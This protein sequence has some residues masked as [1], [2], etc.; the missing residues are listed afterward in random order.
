MYSQKRAGVILTYLTQVIN[1]VSGLVYTPIMLRLLGQSEYGLYQLV[2]SVVSYLGLLS[3]GFSSSYLRFYSRFRADDDEDGVKGLN[4]LFM[5]TFLTIALVS[6]ACGTVLV[7]NIRLVFADGLTEAEYP[8]ATILMAL[9]VVNLALS[10]PNSVFTCWTSAQE[11][12]VFQR[13]L[14]FLGA[15]LSPLVTLPLLILGYGSVAMVVVSTSIT[16]ASLA[17]NA[18]FCLMKLG[19]RFRF[20]GLDWGLF[21]EIFAFTFFIFLNQIIDQVNWSV[22]RFLLGRMR[23]TAAVAIYAVGTHIN[24]I[25]SSLSTA[26]SSVFSPQVNRIVA[27]G[28]EDA[29]EEL[30]DVM[31]KV[32]R[33]QFLVLA[34][35]LTG[36]AFLGYPF[37]LLWGG[38]GY[39]ESYVVAMTVMTPMIVPLIQNI[40]IE[41]QRAKNRHQ[42]RSVVY[43]CIAVLNVAA[44]IPLI[45]AFGPVGGAIG[46]ALALILGNVLFMNW[47]YAYGL[48]VDIARFWGSL[49]RMLPGLVVPC[50]LGAT[51]ATFVPIRDWLAM[52]SCATV[53]AVVYA[54]SMWAVGMNDEERGLAGRPMRR[55]MGRRP[56]GDDSNG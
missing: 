18:W 9:M 1:L 44:S 15:L 19:M 6:V 2:S 41:I 52:V 14:N 24:S 27:E 39:G 46:T 22:D 5:A 4:G 29:D 45:R 54:A 47:Y 21:R 38:E 23:G 11:R 34:L 20:H 48:G 7:A 55:L 37:M 3:F 13:S 51:M 36:F 26:I 28:S 30:T 33:V 49:A 32:G 50:V 40:G 12:F 35:I 42:V 25:Y 17:A 53:Y 10:F 31:I 43:A 8:K 56:T 16:I